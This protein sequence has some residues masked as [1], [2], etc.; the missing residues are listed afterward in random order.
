MAQQPKGP[1][2]RDA[3][4]H[5]ARTDAGGSPADAPLWREPD[6]ELEAIVQS[7]A[8]LFEVS[9]ARVSL[10]GER[11][12]WFEVARTP[13]ALH[14]GIDAAFGAPELD[15]S[16]AVICV[17]DTFLHAQLRSDPLVAAARGIRFYAGAPLLSRTG[18][19]LGMLSVFDYEPHTAGRREVETLRSLAALTM[20][21]I[22]RRA[23]VAA[24]Q[25]REAARRRVLEKYDE[26]RGT[27]LEMAIRNEPLEGQL[28]RI[29]TL[30]ED[31]VAGSYGTIMFV[32]GSVLVGGAADPRVPADYLAAI[33]RMPIDP[34][35][36][37]CASAAYEGVA[38]HLR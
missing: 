37:S 10:R 22:E 13:P 25:E 33:E 6:P 1:M 35:A 5:D 23:E 29:V 17:P 16:A 3:I 27:V 2:E 31:V 32:E 30:L 34:H 28:Q 8:A 11:G 36:D 4:V 19:V 9:I 38:Q 7:A 20:R 18:H 15:D 21:T 24:V 14:A 26:D 12:A